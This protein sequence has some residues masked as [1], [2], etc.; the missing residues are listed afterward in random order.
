MQHKKTGDV[1][2]H[3][4]PIILKYMLLLFIQ[5]NDIRVLIICILDNVN[6]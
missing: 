6:T 1:L 3:P 4:R 5:L 2:Q